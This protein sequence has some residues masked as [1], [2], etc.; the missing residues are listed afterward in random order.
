[1][2]KLLVV[3]ML[4]LA[5]VANAAIDL[6]SGTTEEVISALPGSVVMV[7]A[8]AVV[9]VMQ[10][11]Y[12]LGI[13]LD[14]TVA[15]SF[16]IGG[17]NVGYPGEGSFIEIYDDA[18]T[19]AYV[20]MNNLAVNMSLTDTVEPIA[21]VVGTLV[22]GIALNIGQGIGQVILGVYDSATESI[23]DRI[24]IDV[25]EPIT[26]VLLGLGGLMLRRRK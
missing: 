26:M 23:V 3:L 8:E 19:L 2:K 21:P 25:P 4:A 5:S 11:S 15:A 22:S 16:D 6:G 10:G 18:E 7:D 13:M 9:E 12:M 17:A 1:M 24:I 20:G 14:S